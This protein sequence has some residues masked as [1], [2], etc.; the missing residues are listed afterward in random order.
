MSTLVI[1]AENG[2]GPDEIDLA[3]SIIRGGRLAVVPTDTVY[4][5][6]AI[7]ADPVAVAEVLAAKGRGRQMP[8]P[9]LVPH[10]DAIDELMVNVPD[11]AYQLAQGFW[12][13]ALTLILQAR[14]D[15]GWDLGETNGTLA[16]RMPDHPATVQ[17]L[18][19]TG[20]MAV[21]SANTTGQPPAL[22]CQEAQDYFGTAVDLYIDGGQSRGGVASTIIDLA[23]P[24]PR[25][26]RLGALSLDEINAVA[27]LHLMP[28]QA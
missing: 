10:V 19:A 14:P 18:Q 8:P 20:P 16:V 25:I 22:T 15:L 6:G 2:L 7:A 17:L 11:S 3:A 24:E 13:G 1:D 12:P 4:G 27:G 5:I 21:T 9:V 23:A 28:P 26:I